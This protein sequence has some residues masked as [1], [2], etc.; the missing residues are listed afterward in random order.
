MSCNCNNIDPCSNTAVSCL[1]GVE[2]NIYNPSGVLIETVNAESKDEL[3]AR[4]K[5]MAEH[6]R[7]LKAIQEKQKQHIPNLFFH[8]F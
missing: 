2:F 1:C 3:L 5:Q 7:E 4:E 8:H 6:M